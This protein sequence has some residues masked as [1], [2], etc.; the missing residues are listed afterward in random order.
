MEDV[1]DIDQTA[2]A[3]LEGVVYNNGQ[4]CCAVERVYV[5]EKIFDQFV[6][7]YTKQ[8]KKMVVGDPMNPKTEV[9]PLTRKEQ[10]EFL[11]KQIRDA[12]SKGAKILGGGKRIGTKGYFLDPLSG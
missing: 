11:E 9:G 4:S 6:E 7:S 10:L 1:A 12:E 2:A 8:M 5:H 3:V